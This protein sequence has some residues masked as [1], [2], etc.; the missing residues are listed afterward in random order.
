VLSKPCY[1]GVDATLDLA[2][3]P[4]RVRPGMQEPDAQV[5]ADDAGVIVDEGTAEVGVKLVRNAAS[6]DGL[7][8]RVVEAAGIGSWV[9]LKTGMT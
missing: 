4:G 6:L 2:F 9:I 8:E 1:D 7:L 3:A 5:G